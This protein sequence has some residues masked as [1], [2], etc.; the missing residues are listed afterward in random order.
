[1]V[2]RVFHPVPVLCDIVE[3]YWYVSSPQGEVQEP[4]YFYTPLLQALAFSFNKQVERHVL[5]DKTCLLNKSAYLFG[6]G[7]GPRITTSNEVDY[8]GV[9]F[10]PLGIAN[11]TGINMAHLANQIVDVED[12][13]GNELESLCDE[14][15]STPSLEQRIDVLERFLIKKYL[16]AK[17]CRRIDCAQHA[18]TLISNTQG[19]IDIKTLQEQTNTSR[20]TLERAFTHHIGIGPKLYTR[21]VRFNAAKN[22]LDRLPKH[23]S[24]TEIALESGYYDSSHFNAEFKSFAGCTPFSYLKKTSRDFIIADS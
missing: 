21:I 6:Q 2:Y 10:K 17:V 5:P 1:M 22:R 3:Y 12:V 9:K 7:T 8:L 24:V 16:T 4:Q 19:I 15:Q 18:L 11:M 23:K 13:W 14:M 20:K